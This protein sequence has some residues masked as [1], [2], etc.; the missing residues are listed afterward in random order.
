MAYRLGLRLRLGLKLGLRLGLGLGQRLW[1]RLLYS[2]QLL[3]SLRRLPL[4]KPR[5]RCGAGGCLL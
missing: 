2:R 1:L 5:R 4:H 3:P